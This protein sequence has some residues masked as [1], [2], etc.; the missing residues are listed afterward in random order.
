MGG[1]ADKKRFAT[2][3]AL[4]CAV[5][6]I[7]LYMRRE[8]PVVLELGTDVRADHDFQI[9][10][11]FR[12]RGPERPA[13]FLLTQLKAGQCSSALRRLDSNEASVESSCAKE[14]E[15]PV[16]GW[17]LEARGLDGGRVLLRYRVQ[18][19]YNGDTVSDPFWIWVGKAANSWQ[20]TACEKWY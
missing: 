2:I 18:R 5:V 4:S 14:R 6:C 11:P 3:F 20:V 13:T 16:R 12:D 8:S 7:L 17:R 9:L 10:N 1:L 19:V 15:Y